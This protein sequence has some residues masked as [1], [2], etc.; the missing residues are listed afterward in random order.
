MSKKSTIFALVSL[1]LLCSWFVPGSFFIANAA[2]PQDITDFR[3]LFVDADDG[4]S[5]D[6]Y[7]TS[8]FDTLGLDYESTITKPNVTTMSQ[9][10]IVV[11]H[12]GDYGGDEMSDEYKQDEG[13]LTA[14]LLGGGRLF[15]SSQDWIY[16][17]GLSPF[18]MNY[19]GVANVQ[20][21]NFK[22]NRSDILFG[23]LGDP[24]GGIFLPFNITYP[25]SYT[26][27]GDNL[28]P[29]SFAHTIFYNNTA[30][31]INATAIRN[32]NATYNFKTVFFGVPFEA[33][34]LNRPVL[35]TS[36]LAWLISDLIISEIPG[37]A[38]FLIL[39]GL[40]AI[41]LPCFKQKLSHRNE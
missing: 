41:G 6:T 9:Y 21:D 20:E 14:Y 36:I 25:A 5:W 4:E 26:Q 18:V 30:N 38:F 13:N 19:L 22:D 16:N 7:L 35:M 31:P 23:T 39:I 28:Q 32:Q 29:A 10:T 37:F 2:N 3:I 33:F 12:T 27:Y 8:I 1:F 17:Q 34:N 40:L 15:L 24:I 11:W